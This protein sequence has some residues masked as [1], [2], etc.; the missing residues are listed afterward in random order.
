MS[1]RLRSIGR[2]LRREQRGFSLMQL[3]L[4]VG[5]LS[6]ILIA[7]LSL[8]DTTAKLAPRDQ[9]RAA[10]LDETK[11]GLHR[12]TRELRQAHTIEISSAFDIQ[13]RV[14]PQG[15]EKQIRYE[16]DQIHPT[17]VAWR[18][19]VR[20]DVTAGNAQ[21]LVLDR[22]LNIPPAGSSTPVFTYTTHPGGERSVEVR[23]ETP[24]A[25]DRKD[26]QHPH[27]VVLQDGFYL[28]NV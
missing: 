25:G 1:I 13:V 18:R 22:V 11:A 23:I 21:Q 28:R 14:G 2:R 8:T 6:V 27:R 7:I 9:E 12:M 5:L 19:C 17:N 16:C 4:A 20:F 24:A 15:A 3:M 26:G 10:V